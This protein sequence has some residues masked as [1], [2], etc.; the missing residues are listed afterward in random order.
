MKKIMVIIWAVFWLQ[1][2]EAQLIQI[3]LKGGLNI[4]NLKMESSAATN[5]MV[6]NYQG[7]HAGLVGRVNLVLFYVQPE[8][9]YTYSSNTF[10]FTYN[11]NVVSDEEY[12]VSRIDVPVPVGFKIG[13]LAMFAGPVMSFN[14]SA[15][16]DIFDDMYKTS[17]WGYQAGVGVKISRLLAEFKYE[18]PF[19]NTTTQAVVNGQTINFDSKLSMFILSFGV[20]LN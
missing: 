11:G 3:G 18:G 4:P 13:P 15:P 9:I 6:D 20:F 12:L 10:S 1:N 5:I 17:E 14:I 16:S 2:A 19:S 8:L 7:F